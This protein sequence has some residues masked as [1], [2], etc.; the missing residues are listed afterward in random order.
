MAPRLPFL[1]LEPSSRPN[2][3]QGSLRSPTSLHPLPYR[4]FFSRTSPKPTSSLPINLFPKS[5][6]D[7]NVLR[8]WVGGWVEL[9][10]E[11]EWWMY[12]ESKRRGDECLVGWCRGENGEIREEVK[13]GGGRR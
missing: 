10:M 11:G 4:R 8:G 9:K 6:P 12:D 5:L 13:V 7:S 2:T 1:E 3:F